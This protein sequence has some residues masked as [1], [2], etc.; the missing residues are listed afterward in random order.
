ME[1]RRL[2]RTGQEVSVLGFG[3]FHLLEIPAREAA[4]LLNRYLDA[5]GNYVETAAAYGNGESELK[6]GAALAHRRDEIFL[7]TK[8]IARDKKGAAEQIDR[9]LQNL[10]TDRVDLLFMHA[11]GTGEQLGQILAPGGAL[12]AA[13]EARA[14]GKIRFLGIS[15]HGQPD[16]LIEGITRYPFD[17]V[18]ATFNYFDRFNFPDLEGKL[19][20][21]ARGKDLGLVLMKPLADGFLWRSAPVAFRYA[22]SLPVSVVVTGM[23]TKEMLEAD[24]AYVRDFQ[25]MSAKEKEELFRSAP[26]LGEYVCRQCDACLPCPKGVPIPEIFRLEGYYDRQMRDGKARDPAEYA[27]RERLRFWYGG[28]ERA[29]QQY[30]DLPVKAAACIGCGECLPRCPYHLAIVEKLGIADYKLSGAKRYF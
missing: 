4:Y 12:E 15:M 6:V 24:L 11:V 23:N 30:Q 8:C 17:A 5:G 25:P 21:L 10:Q 9:S 22:L 27:L 16:T 28:Q 7:A 13:E 18:M 3:G 26:E 20:P 14:Q 1:R 29:R 2:G 19:L